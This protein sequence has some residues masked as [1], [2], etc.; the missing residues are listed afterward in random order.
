LT[1]TIR[2]SEADADHTTNDIDY[3]TGAAAYARRP[4]F[5][6][7]DLGVISKNTC[8]LKAMVNASLTPDKSA[9]VLMAVVKADAYGHGIL[10][11]ADCVLKNGADWLG[12]ALPR[13]ALVLRKAGVTAPIL[14]LG[15]SDPEIHRQLIREDVRMAIYSLDQRDALAAA[16]REEGKKARVHIKVDTGMHRLGFTPDDKA[17]ED[18]RALAAIP[19][20][21]LEGCFTHFA[22]ADEEDRSSWHAQLETF[23]SFLSKLA[24]YGLSFSIVHCANTAAGM[25]DPGSVMD[26]YRAGIGI[27]GLYPS[28]EARSLGVVDLIPAL[29]WKSFLSHVK[30]VP[31][32]G[33]V[34]YGHIWIAEK[35]TLVGTVPVG[36][37]DG[38]RRQFENGGFVLIHGKRAPV[39]GKICMDQFMVDLSDVSEAAAGDEVVLLGK[40]GD[41]AISADLLADLIGTSCY[42][43]VCMIGNRIPRNYV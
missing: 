42:E 37:A 19:E 15:Y 25:F 11:I 6:E 39:I 14:V 22:R 2:C 38:Y 27:Y 3:G 36:Y 32:G 5:V 41:D 34:S 35:D 20:F 10:R 9:P 33:G 31:R 12:V 24:S 18:I 21:V 23:E 28:E 13:E 4:S 7:V 16:A 40:Q 8:R 43:I 29:S 1:K 30:T 26:M 17:I